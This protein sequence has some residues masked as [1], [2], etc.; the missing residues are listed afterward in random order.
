MSVSL[1]S[2][3]LMGRFTSEWSRCG[4]ADSANLKD[5]HY[6]SSHKLQ[7]WLAAR[8]RKQMRFMPTGLG[9]RTIGPRGKDTL[10]EPRK[11]AFIR[12]TVHFKTSRTY[13]QTLFP[14]QH[15]TFTAPNTMITASLTCIDRG[16]ELGFH[17]RSMEL[18]FHDVQFCAG[19]G[20]PSGSFI[21]LRL[22][23]DPERAIENRELLGI[24][25]LVCE[26]TTHQYSHDTLTMDARYMGE[27]IARCSFDALKD[28]AEH[29]AEQSNGI[30][31][32]NGDQPTNGIEDH[33]SD[34]SK[35]VTKDWDTSTKP[36][37]EEP[38]KS[39]LTYKYIPSLNGSQAD[40]EYA[41]F[42]P[43][44]EALEGF[45]VIG[46]ERVCESSAARFVF[47]PGPWGPGRLVRGIARMM[48]DMPQLGVI[49]GEVRKGQSADCEMIAKKL[50]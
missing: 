22:E 15:F 37:G 6:H 44:H 3:P 42:I 47:E 31:Q 23:T 10:S 20:S 26:M 8:G 32:S 27:H 43:N 48:E 13:A 25:S 41:I 36:G 7:E 1:H 33:I 45:R 34:K 28:K 11:K 35:T 2:D 4:Y 50:L 39:F 21:A 40:A 17:R 18:A 38:P 9:V 14:S 24:P 46:E 29:V 12:A 49:S 30:H 19:G 5:E 16:P